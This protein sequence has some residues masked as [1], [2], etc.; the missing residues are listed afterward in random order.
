MVLA[1]RHQAAEAMRITH[2]KAAN[3]HLN[4]VRRTLDFA[5]RHHLDVV[6]EETSVSSGAFPP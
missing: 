4:F 1:V 5:V 6:S 2:E 3:K